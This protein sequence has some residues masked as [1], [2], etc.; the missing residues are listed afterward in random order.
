MHTHSC[1]QFELLQ[2]FYNFHGINCE[3][4]LMQ[5]EHQIVEIETLSAKLF[6]FYCV[7][8]MS[9]K[10][11][12]SVLCKSAVN[13]VTK[14]FYISS[15]ESLGRWKNDNKSI[16]CSLFVRKILSGRRRRRRR[17]EKGKRKVRHE[18]WHIVKHTFM[19]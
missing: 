13:N 7:S 12:Q 2:L 19:S 14:L 15:H 16:S 10:I 6:E 3:L 1:K 18:M 8:L 4:I 11:H 5:I 9:N 17:K